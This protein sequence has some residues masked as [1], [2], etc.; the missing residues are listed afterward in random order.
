MFLSEPFFLRERGTSPFKSFK[1]DA[2]II[3]SLS[4]FSW[5]FTVFGF[6]PLKIESIFLGP[7]I[8]CL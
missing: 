2:L 7:D 8:S 3:E 6:N 5:I 4:R 1:D